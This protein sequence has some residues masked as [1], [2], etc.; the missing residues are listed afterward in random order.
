MKLDNIKINKENR[1]G[2]RNIL[3]RIKYKLINLF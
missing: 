3:L 2:G 1:A